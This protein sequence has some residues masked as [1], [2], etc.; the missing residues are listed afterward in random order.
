MNF[1]SRLNKPSAKCEIAGAVI[2]A[3]LGATLGVGIAA[4]TFGFATPLLPLFVA[5]G[6]ALGAALGYWIGGDCYQILQKQLARRRHL[7]TL[8]PRPRDSQNVHVDMPNTSGSHSETPSSQGCLTLGTLSASC[9]DGVI[10][11]TCMALRGAF[12]VGALSV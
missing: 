5:L 4:L 10:V 1:F 11:L 8:S 12:E 9:L 6:F 7:E 3:T 2:G